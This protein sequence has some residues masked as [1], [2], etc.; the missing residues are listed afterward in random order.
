MREINVFS[1]TLRQDTN[2]ELARRAIDCQLQYYD[3][4]DATFRAYVH[5]ALSE[6]AIQNVTLPRQKP[7]IVA[8]ECWRIVLEEATD[9]D[10]DDGYEFKMDVK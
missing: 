8:A 1:S 10:V 2:D 3:E 9:A 6:N 4:N 5:F 7:R